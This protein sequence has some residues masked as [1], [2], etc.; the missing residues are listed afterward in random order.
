MTNRSGWLTFSSVMLMIAGL[1]R[2]IDGIWALQYHG[3]IPNDL[4]NALLGHN[5][6]TY[7]WIGVIMGI[8]LI[9]AGVLV[10]GP[11]DQPSAEVSRFIG[12]LSASLG[13]I[14]A[15]IL[16]PYYPVWALIYVALSVMVIY[17]LTAH[18]GDDSS[19]SSSHSST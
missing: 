14:S 3:A 2:V 13:A 17:G 18:F 7:G 15:I 16:V 11:G 8:I 9:A 6:T 10:M 12:V 4:K 1:M 5:L 19:H